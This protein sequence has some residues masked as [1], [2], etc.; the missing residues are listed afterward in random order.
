MRLRPSG[1]ISTEVKWLAQETLPFFIRGRQV[2]VWPKEKL[3]ELPNKKFMIASG[4]V[5]VCCQN[6]A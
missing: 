1:Y 3:G 6:M 5:F 4:Y 2:R